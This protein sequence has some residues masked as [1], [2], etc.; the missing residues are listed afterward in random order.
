MPA[1]PRRAGGLPLW[2]KGKNLPARRTKSQTKEKGARAESGERHEREQSFV[3]ER[4]VLGTN[5]LAR[6]GRKPD[7]AR[8]SERAQARW[9]TKCGAGQHQL[10]PERILWALTT[11]GTRVRLAVASVATPPCATEP[12]FPD[13]TSCQPQRF[14]AM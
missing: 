14:F 11:F 13:L 6:L 5:P 10:S 12:Y 2:N 1:R 8:D 4:L 3:D 9:P 7:A